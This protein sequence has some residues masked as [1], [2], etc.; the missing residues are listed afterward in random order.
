MFTKEQIS[1]VT[2][3][4][5]SVLLELNAEESKTNGKLGAFGKRVAFN[6]KSFSCTTEIIEDSIHYKKGNFTVGV[7]YI[8]FSAPRIS[9]NEPLLLKQTKDQN[10]YKVRD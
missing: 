4:V 5:A 10:S 6:E 1:S 8:T 3:E 9:R 2:P 7:E